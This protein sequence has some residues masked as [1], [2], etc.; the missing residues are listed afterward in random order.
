MRSVV[1]LS[2]QEMLVALLRMAV[3]MKGCGQVCEDSK[4]LVI[5]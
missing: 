2:V 1:S 5:D 4:S 3:K